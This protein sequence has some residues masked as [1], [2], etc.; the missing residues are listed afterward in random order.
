MSFGPPAL[1]PDRWRSKLP[2]PRRLSATA[3]FRRVVAGATVGVAGF[4]IGS[5]EVMGAGLRCDD[6]CNSENSSWRYS[7]D[8][9]QWTAMGWLG[10]AC[11]VSSLAFAISLRTRRTRLSLALLAVALTSGVAPLLLGA[12]G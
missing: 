1:P 5:V 2:P 9:W 11:G 7:P 3:I 4:L 6:W 12:S 8:A 10:A